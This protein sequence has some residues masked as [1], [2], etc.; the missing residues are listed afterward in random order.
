[1]I[2]YIV[3]L[4]TTICSAQTTIFVSLTGNNT[5]GTGTI[6][7]PYKTIEKAANVAENLI[8]TNPTTPVEILIRAGIYRSANFTTFSTIPTTSYDPQNIG[9]AIWKSQPIYTAVELININGRSTAWITIKPYNNELVEIEGDGDLAV[10][11]RNCSYLKFEGLKIKGIYDKLPL[12]LAWKYWGTYRYQNAGNWVY[13]DR[14]QEICTLYSLTNCTEIPPIALQTDVTYTGLPDISTLNV[15]RPNIFGGK[16]IL[17]NLSNNITINNCEV[18]NF[19]GGG[20][21][22]TGSD[23]I[24]ITNNK[25]HHNSL[26]APVGTHGLVIEGLGPDSGSNTTVQ[27]CYIANN[28]VYSN[29]NECYSWVQ[30]KTICTTVIDEGKG[31]ALL[32]TGSING[33]N[34]IIRVENNICY[35]NGKS[36]VHCNDVDNAE[37]YNNTCYNNAHTNIYNATLNGG[38]NCGISIQSSNN[39]K[40]KNNIVVVPNVTPAVQALSEGQ[41][42]TGEVVANNIIFGGATSDFPGGFTNVNPLFSNPLI[43]DFSLQSTS[44]G[45]NPTGISYFPT[46]DF[47]GFNR[48]A[49]PDIGAIEYYFGNCAS[50]VNTWNGSSWSSGNPKVNQQL[51]FTGNYSSTSNLQ[52]CSVIVNNNAQVVINAGH[53]LIVGNGITVNTGSSLT[54]ENNAALIQLEPSTTNNTGVIVVKRNSAPMRRLDYTAWSSPVLNQKLQSFSPNTLPTRFYTYDFTGTTTPTA[55]LAVANPS[56]TNFA[57]AKGYLIRAANNWTTTPTIFNGT[58]T[59]TPLNGNRNITPGVGYNLIGNPYPSPIDATT[60]LKD[61]TQIEALYFWSNTIPASG[62]T[63]PQNNYATYSLLGGVASVSGSAVPNG[64]IQTGQ[65]V[66]VKATTTTIVKFRNSQRMMANSSTQFFRN[67]TPNSINNEEEK[68]TIRLNLNYETTPVYQ[69]L[70]GSHVLA[71]DEK[72]LQIDAEVFDNSKTCLYSIIN[73]KE[74]AIQGIGLNVPNSKTINLGLNITQTGTYNIQLEET[75]GLFEEKNIYLY[76]NLKN[77]YT[78]LKVTQCTIDLAEG[79]YDNRFQLVF[80]KKIDLNQPNNNNVFI[81]SK[82]NYNHIKATQPIK[83]VEVYDLLGKLSFTQQEINNNEFAFAKMQ[84]NG[85]YF[86]KVY[87]ENETKNFKIIE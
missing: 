78:D 51:V 53:T 42:C 23:F 64:I 62:G 8:N 33:F 77:T 47:Y 57:A 37:I 22:A 28:Q 19:P 66:Y 83:S 50:N 31:I 58:F 56:T 75:L 81:Y 21:R 38:T 68:H 34:G 60:L 85:I 36:G 69:T 63:Y 72:D 52:G 54:I 20:V 26:R 25:V 80:E 76:D 45:I 35:D 48:D 18:Y 29:Y 70:I 67:N 30:S 79:K 27:K 12:E 17:V 46:L 65:G 41:N 11:I 10:N 86:I 71:S 39:I 2:K 43:N 7:N 74:Y 55:F 40:I 73:N 5:T 9:E 32:R 82:E 6:S 14:K 61:N 87:L 24:T 84:Q 49:T 3:I 16:G 13:G 44:T 4:L 59:G 1:M 15:E